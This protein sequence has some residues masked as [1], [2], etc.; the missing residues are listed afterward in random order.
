MKFPT[1][2]LV[3][4]VATVLAMPQY[5]SAQWEQF[6]GPKATQV[7]NI[8]SRG[9][10]LFASTDKGIFR[11][12]DDGIRWVAVNSG[13]PMDTIFLNLA[14][15]GTDIF[16]LTIVRDTAQIL[17]STDNGKNWS[18]ASSGLP[19]DL[20]YLA[21]IGKRLFVFG[22]DTSSYDEGIYRL[23]DFGESW[24]LIGEETLDLS[25]PTI[26]TV[27]GNELYAATDNEVYRSA[28]FGDNWT[29]VSVDLTIDKSWVEVKKGIPERVEITSLVATGD[30]LFAGA[31][32]SEER[33]E[34]PLGGVSTHDGA[35]FDAL[36]RSIDN[37]NS[38]TLIHWE[39]ES[40]NT[41]D[42]YFYEVVSIGDTLFACNWNGVYRSTNKG[43]Y[44]RAVDT[45]LPVEAEEQALPLVTALAVMGDK[46]FAGTWD[47]VY[48]SSDKG[49]SWTAANAGLP[50]NTGIR[51]LAVSG[52]YLYASLGAHGVY[53]SRDVA[54]T[55]LPVGSGSMVIEVDD[56]VPI[57]TDLFVTT[58]QG[59]YKSKND[60]DSWTAIK[61]MPGFNWKVSI[62]ALGSDIYVGASRYAYRS[63]DHGENW[64]ALIGT[65]S[66]WG[67]DTILAN[68]KNLFL[69][70]GEL[71]IYRS[72]IDGEN[73]AQLDKRGL[74]FYMYL[75]KVGQRLFASHYSG[76]FMSTDDGDSWVAVNSGLP[77]PPFRDTA[78][79]TRTPVQKGF[80][81]LK[82]VGDQLFVSTK[83]GVFKFNDETED[84][85]PIN[86]GL[87]ANTLVAID[88]SSADLFA[89]TRDAGIW[90]LRMSQLPGTEE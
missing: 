61:P 2:T 16:A 88:D 68:G 80:P 57:G 64:T 28:D 67:I 82:A 70:A 60:G 38:W 58:A 49:E 77:T 72:E 6:N 37:G 43:E 63:S 17:R 3:I 1:L 42:A 52:T 89:H 39:Q 7:N 81:V 33:H 35:T 12:E 66:W 46:L 24:Q 22:S 8:E 84:W 29:L 54:K 71:G 45:G 55:W 47:G 26:L 27:Q 25:Y 56:I 79:N 36:F 4:G 76:I 14:V 19:D 87:P 69:T 44:W 74:Y 21:V 53:R 86:V 41:G 32:I 50:R 34:R 13:L 78:S 75:T 18:V 11:S 73:W 85:T 59:L 48:V 30:S 90:R 65:P 5:A 15:I 10:Y 9:P 20:Y 23:T 62:S 51:S 31:W 40:D 83:E